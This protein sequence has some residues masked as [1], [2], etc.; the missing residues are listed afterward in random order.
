MPHEKGK[1]LQLAFDVAEKLGI[2]PLLD[3]ED[4]LL[5]KPEQFSV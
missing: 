2:P 5:P 3:V 4:M 1:N